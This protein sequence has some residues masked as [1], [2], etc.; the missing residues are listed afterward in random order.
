MLY[1]PPARHEDFHFHA[2]YIMWGCIKSVQDVLGYV[3]CRFK[4]KYFS[5]LII[6][7][8]GHA[9]IING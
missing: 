9:K 1:K 4:K 3:G 8:F 2:A 5:G 6:R 7:C